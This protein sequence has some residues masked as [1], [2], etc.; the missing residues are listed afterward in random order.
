MSEAYEKMANLKAAIDNLNFMNGI[1]GEILHM[2]G[3]QDTQGK[4]NKTVHELNEAV[5]AFANASSK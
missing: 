1:V 5:K 4:F 2:N 3:Y